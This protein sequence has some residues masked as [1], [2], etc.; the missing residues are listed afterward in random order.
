MEKAIAAVAT[1]N[2]AAGI[3]VIRISGENA[4]EI[5]D[6][7]FKPIDGSSLA[8]L[9]GYRAKFGNIVCDDEVVDNAVALVF[10]APKSYTGENVVELSVHGGIFIVEKTL[11]AVLDAGAQAAG[12]GEFTK[13]AFLNGKIDL[14]QA[15]SVADLISAQGDAAARA[16]F[17]MLQGALSDKI[18]SVLER[19]MDCSAELAAWVDYPDEEFP[20]LDDETLKKTLL[21]CGDEL[22]KL[23]KDYD[24][25]KT[26]LQ[27]ITTV[28]A[29]KP[30]VGK[31]TLM[32]LLAGEEKSI[33]TNVRGTTRDI[34]EQT[35][36][37]GDLVLHLSDTAGIRRTD[38]IVEAIGVERACKRIETADL[39][40]PV[41]D[42]S[43]G[44]GF[45]DRNLIERCSGKN[46]VA[47]INKIDL[48]Q[49]L[50]YD[51]I[52]SAF[53][54]CVFISARD[55][56]KT[57]DLEKEIREV[58]G[59]TGFDSSNVILANQRQKMCCKKAMDN[60]FDAISCLI[61]GVTRDAINVLI[62]D[63][64]NELL[65]LTGRKATEEVVNN[66][67]SKFCVGK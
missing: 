39:I 62:D 4:I 51:E 60:V 46:A 20:E 52:T 17:N 19:L 66:I 42:S 41:F 55:T 1:G 44:L 40:L 35:V 56:D 53:D 54:H 48:K 31:S 29:G 22:R 10:R 43:R 36:R 13:R 38:D 21:D 30:N 5:A 26:M 24:K 27:G 33:V 7:V 58:L 64:I 34:I 6:K 11:S 28:I 25:G 32:N 3:G 37:L 8:A 65:S 9:S 12:P 59:I 2:A 45:D 14:T 16:S 67:F 49:K 57:D 15:E 63:A 18:N 47:I 23:L 61:L 50:N